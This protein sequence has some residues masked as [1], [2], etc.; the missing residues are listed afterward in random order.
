MCIHNLRLLISMYII[1]EDDYLHQ[2]G[3]AGLNITIILC[4]S[5]LGDT[6]IGSQKSGSL[7]SQIC[8]ITVMW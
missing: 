1:L 2:L 8:I 3:Y 4:K 6:M 5:L 7:I